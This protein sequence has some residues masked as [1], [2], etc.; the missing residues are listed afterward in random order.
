MLEMTYD[1]FPDL[2]ITINNL[3]SNEA[4]QMVTVE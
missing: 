3:I 1:F 4:E 2:K